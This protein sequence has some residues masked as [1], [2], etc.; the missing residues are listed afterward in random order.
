MIHVSGL[1]EGLFHFPCN[2]EMTRLDTNMHLTPQEGSPEQI[3]IFVFFKM[4]GL[5]KHSL[6]IASLERNDI[7]RIS[8]TSYIIGPP[9]EVAIC[10]AGD[11]QLPVNVM[12]R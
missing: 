12:L 7:D 10:Q 2:T 9:H 3:T 11:K 6:R 5:R 4:I 8:L 1:Q